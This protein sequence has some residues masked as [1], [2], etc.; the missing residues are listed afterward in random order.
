MRHVKFELGAIAYYCLEVFRKNERYYDDYIPLSM[1]S[2]SND[3]YNFMED[4]YMELY[5]SDGVTLKAAW[6]RYKAYCDDA[7]VTFPYNRRVFKEELKSYFED[8]FDTY[9]TGTGTVRSYYKGF[10]RSKFENAPKLDK[11]VESEDD[12]SDFVWEEQE[13]E[14]DKMAREWPAQ[15]AKEDDTPKSK[16]EF[17]TTKLKDIDVT[18]VHYVLVPE[19]HIVIDFDIK[20]E[21]GN[22]CLAKNIEAARLWPPTYAEISKG[23]NGI[24]LHYIYDS[25]VSKL[26]FTL[27]VLK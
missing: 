17:V 13:S 3:F 23:G 2:A 26:A 1:M 21:Y 18:K 7:K 9:E 27:M 15:Y 11:P 16:W 5:K 10:K 12:G 19:N 4:M 22:K 24:H 6:E 8:F 14:F 20:D 25:D